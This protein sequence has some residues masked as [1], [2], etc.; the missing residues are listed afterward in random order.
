MLTQQNSEVQHRVIGDKFTA[1]QAFQAR[2]S[3]DLAVELFAGAVSLIES[4]DV[5][6][7]VF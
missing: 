6:N 1:W 7:R 2:F 5:L 3:L 4:S